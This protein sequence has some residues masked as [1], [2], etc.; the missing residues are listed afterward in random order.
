MTGNLGST[1]GLLKVLEV[2]KDILVAGEFAK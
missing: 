2:G 1:Y